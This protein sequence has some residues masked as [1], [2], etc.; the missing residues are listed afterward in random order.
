M[1]H[2]MTICASAELVASAAAQQAWI[3]ML[4]DSHINVFHKGL[5]PVGG[6]VHLASIACGKNYAMCLNHRQASSH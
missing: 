3:D 6:G 2:H 1:M 5:C 4:H